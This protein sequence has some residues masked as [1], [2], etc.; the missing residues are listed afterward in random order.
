MFDRWKNRRRINSQIREVESR[1]QS[2]AKHGKTDTM[3]YAVA[4]SRWEIDR[5]HASL[6]ELEA[7]PWLEWAKRHRIKIT[8]R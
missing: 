3:G 5:L 7:E 8:G 1:I 4:N 6:R 2:T